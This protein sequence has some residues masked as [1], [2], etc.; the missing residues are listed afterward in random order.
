MNKD[1]VEQFFIDQLNHWPEVA[2]RYAHLDKLK[3][4][5]IHL[6]GW[7]AKVVF[8]PLRKI[9]VTAAPDRQSTPDACPLCSM[10]RP[11]EQLAL[12][13]HGKY[14]ILINPYPIFRKHFTIIAN[15][16][17]PQQIDSR[18][19]DMLDL[20]RQME[21]YTLLYNGPG[22]GASLPWH[23]HFQAIERGNLP[24]EDVVK[25]TIESDKTSESFLR[26]VNWFYSFFVLAAVNAKGA[27][28]LFNR[29]LHSLPQEQQR[30]N[31]LIAWYEN[32]RWYIAIVLRKAHRPD[33]YYKTGEKQL[34]ISPA[35]VEMGGV[36][37]TI[38]REDYDKINS[39]ILGDIMQQVVATPRPHTVNVGIIESEMIR[40]S[41]NTPYL[42]NDNNVEGEITLRLEEGKVS[43]KNQL[44]DS[45]VFV[46]VDEN[47]AYIKVYDVL[48][49]KKFH[50][51]QKQTLKFRG[52]WKVIARDDKLVGINILGI[53]EYLK[54]VI[55]SEMSP[56]APLESLKAHAVISR[57]WLINQIQSRKSSVT[58]DD[59]GLVWYD[60]SGH[61][62]YDVCADDHCQR[63][64]GITQITNAAALRAIEETGGEVLLDVA[65]EVID[66]RYSKCCGGIIEEYQYAWENNP[67]TYAKAKWDWLNDDLLP[68]FGNENAAAE[69]VNT[70]PTAWC[71]VTDPKV[72]AATMKN[73]DQKTPDFYRWT[74]AY[75]LNELSTIIQDKTGIN[76]GKLKAIVPLNRGKSGRIYKLRIEGSLHSWIIGKELEIRRVLS[77]THL[78]SSAFVVTNQYN[79]QGMLTGFIF[80][81]AG[82]G[83]GVGLCQ[84]G[85]ANMAANGYRYEA[86]LRH[87][88]PET[89]LKKVYD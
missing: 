35:T 85:A 61:T 2:E 50:W 43:Y 86:I 6:L 32:N 31:N 45:L 36:I 70:A 3:E 56:D 84:I 54:S 72:I 40:F 80:R 7:N 24:I 28:D 33:Y 48:I 79:E 4:R 60:S 62:A 49:G 81:G 59:E 67:K 17:I 83:H 23:A 11:A 19:A 38:R 82:W 42:L 78:Y 47:T 88:Y 27:T 10:N 65:G 22:A 63:Y 29:L 64:Q 52:A 41:L 16:H 8:N 77:R 68:D 20:A 5:D 15:Q 46:P 55:S 12:D 9:S 34:I 57:S 13:F 51:E 75:N 37:V 25:H 44:Y 71:N 18:F 69:W 53:E 66:A 87:Y 39:Q 89:Q 21:G 76:P 1:I 30:M 26:K 58:T 73:Y 14:T 74:V